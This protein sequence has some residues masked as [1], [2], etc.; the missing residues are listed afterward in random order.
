M[1]RTLRIL[2]LARADIDRIYDW[3]AERSPAGAATWYDA[4]VAE[5]QRILQHPESCGVIPEARPRWGR[6]IYQAIFKTAQG[7]PYRLIFELTE[8]EVRVLRVR[9][10]GQRPLRP[11]D[12]GTE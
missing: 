7:N 2:A 12:L 6:S 5:T 11:R 3:L 9:G 1:S 10:P 8:T 4:L